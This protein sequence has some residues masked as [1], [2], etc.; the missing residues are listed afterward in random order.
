MILPQTCDSTQPSQPAVAILFL[1]T[2]PSIYGIIKLKKY[3]PGKETETM[4]FFKGLHIDMKAQTMRFPYL[5][6]MILDA[7]EKGFNMIMLE[8]QDKFPYTG[9]L[10]ILAGPDALTVEEIE[11]IKTICR[12]NDIELIPMVQCLGHMDWVT[13]FAEFAPLSEMYPNQKRGCPSLCSRNPGTFPLIQRMTE[14]VLAMHPEAKYFFIGGD[15][16]DVSDECP[17]CGGADKGELL[18]EYYGKVIKWISEKNITPMMWADMLLRY[19]NISDYLPKDVILVDWEYCKGMTRAQQKRFYGDREPL[20][21]VCD[22]PFEGAIRLREK[23]FRVITAPALR[24]WSDTI[25]LPRNAHLDNCAAAF[26]TAKDN[27]MDG[28]L[29]TSWA[30]RRNPWWLAEPVLCAMAELFRDE[31]AT[32]EDMARRYAKDAFHSD[33]PSLVWISF[34]L[35]KAVE[36]AYREADMISATAIGVNCDTGLS[37]TGHLMYQLNDKELRKNYIIRD[38][39]RDM[40]EAGEKAKAAVLALGTPTTSAKFLLW[41]AEAAIFYG[42]CVAELCFRYEDPEWTEEMLARIDAYMP[43]VQMLSEYFSDYT[44]LAEVKSRID[45]FKQYVKYLHDK[46]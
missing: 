27:G 11:E 9:D 37:T 34:D 4:G 20:A 7:I 32:A 33:D 13:R 12:E 8:Y 39:Y 42:N 3:T 25:F 23:G 31:N 2:I 5:R 18:G 15:E 22:D 41:A 26:Y 46:K 38:A 43:Q 44:M 16:V 10:A 14:P 1:L 21:P 29:V 6:Q 30:L 35:S 19:K 45:V 40:A 24:S 28:I 17:L 36:R